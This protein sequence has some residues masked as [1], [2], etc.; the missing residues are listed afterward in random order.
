[1]N[2]N[3][4]LQK[5]LPF[6]VISVWL[7][8]S[9]NLDEFRWDLYWIL[10]IFRHKSEERDT[11]QRT[12]NANIE[13]SSSLTA[14]MEENWLNNNYVHIE[15]HQNFNR[16]YQA[17]QTIYLS[18]H[19]SIIIPGYFSL[20]I[21]NIYHEHYLAFNGRIKLLTKFW[22]R[23]VFLNYSEERTYQYW[24]CNQMSKDHLSAAFHNTLKVLDLYFV[25]INKKMRLPHFL[26]HTIRLRVQ[27]AKLN[28]I[29]IKNIILF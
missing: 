21:D 18:P 19:W 3:K 4:W 22:L 8:N 11:H 13:I 28:I 9:L 17:Y 5:D 23:L 24:K 1:M 15:L 16:T 12:S 14:I 6:V 29:F 26:S 7:K 2:W 10:A 25:F 20:P 27:L